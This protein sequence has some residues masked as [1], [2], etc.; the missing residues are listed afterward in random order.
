MM[1]IFSSSINTSI[2]ITQKQNLTNSM[3]LDQMVFRNGILQTAILGR[4]T[5]A[6]DKPIVTYL[7]ELN[8]KIKKNSNRAFELSEDGSEYTPYANL[9]EYAVLFSNTSLCTFAKSL[10]LK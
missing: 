1:L 5:K 8:A 10:Q 4:D 6:M 2:W 9:Q 3:I 7:D